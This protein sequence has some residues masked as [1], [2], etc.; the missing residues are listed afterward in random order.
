VAILADAAG[1]RPNQLDEGGV[2]SG[3]MR[4]GCGVSAP[5]GPST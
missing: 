3:V 4:Y 5:A 2:H 1:A